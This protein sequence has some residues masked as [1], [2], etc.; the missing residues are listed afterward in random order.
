[1]QMTRAKEGWLRLGTG[2]ILNL[3]LLV[4][5]AGPAGRWGGYD[6]E[7]HFALIDI[8]VAAPAFV[9]VMP[10]FWRGEPW[11]TQL[12]IIRVYAIGT[13]VRERVVVSMA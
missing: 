11:Q 8:A 3:V 2:V 12:R 5:S 4:L 6:R 1:M 10:L 7:A 13:R 9:T